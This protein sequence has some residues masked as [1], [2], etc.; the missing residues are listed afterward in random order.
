MK[1]KSPIEKRVSQA[2][3][4]KPDLLAR[5]KK[6]AVDNDYRSFSH[7]VESLLRQKLEGDE[8]RSS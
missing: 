8:K 1:K 7:L 4:I 5:A 3:S 6:Y 2:V